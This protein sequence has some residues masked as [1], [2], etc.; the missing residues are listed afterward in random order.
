MLIGLCDLS[1]C[2]LFLLCW[3]GGKWMS[4]AP[5]WMTFLYSWSDSYTLCQIHFH[6]VCGLDITLCHLPYSFNATASFAAQGFRFPWV[7]CALEAVTGHPTAV[8]R[9][10]GR[11]HA[12]S[13]YGLPGVPKLPPRTAGN[14]LQVDSV[15]PCLYNVAFLLACSLQGRICC[16]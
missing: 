16:T 8:C 3:R 2:L 11:A 13:M 6:T 14:A 5:W 15:T 12:I 10:V 9:T 7:P 1:N 4:N